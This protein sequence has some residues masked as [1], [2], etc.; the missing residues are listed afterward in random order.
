MRQGHHRPAQA[1]AQI[2]P[3]CAV[4]HRHTTRHDHSAD[5]REISA[6][7]Q[8]RPVMRQSHHRPTQAAAQ[9]G[10]ACAVPHGYAIHSHSAGVRE[11]P[12]RIQVR[13]VMQQGRHSIV[14]TAAQVCPSMAW[15]ESTTDLPCR[16]HRI[17]ASQRGVALVA[18]LHHNI[19]H[20]RRPDGRNCDR[21][22]VRSRTLNRRRHAAHQHVRDGAEVSIGEGDGV[23]SRVGT[24]IG[25]K[26][27][28]GTAQ[29]QRERRGQIVAGESHRRR[30]AAYRGGGVDHR[31]VADAADI[32]D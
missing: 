8:V 11:F 9:I 2:G 16:I 19:L 23:A 29:I 15:Y 4:P 22:P 20:A 26:D 18:R 10:P 28:A 24:D 31:E 1:V 32:H 21:R 6:R 13:P 12:P 14:Y 17:R 7:I 3:A 5:I 30:M 25:R 27:E